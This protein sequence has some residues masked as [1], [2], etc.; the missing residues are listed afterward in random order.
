[1]KGRPLK[2]VVA[3][4]AIGFPMGG[5]L[6]MMMHYVLGLKQLGHE[7]L[8]LEDTSDWSYAYDPVRRS[9]DV[10]SSYG[11]RVL[12]DFFRRNGLEGQWVYNSALENRIYGRTRQELDRFCSEADLWLSLSGTNPL[13]E[14]YMRCRVKA[15]IDT[16]PVFTQ[17][18]IRDD[19]ITRDYFKAHD[20]CFTWGYN[21]PSLKT[22]VPL[23]GIDWKPTLPPILLEKWAPVSPPGRS[24]NT[25][26][27][28]DTKG[29][30]I[31]LDGEVFSWRKRPKYERLIDLPGQLPGL[32]LEIAFMGIE[33]DGPRYADHGWIL[34]DPVAV[35]ADPYNYMDYIKNSRAEFTVA[36]DQNVKLKSGWFSDRSASYLAAGRPV[37]TEDTGF[38]AYLPVGE[39]IF[40]YE[41]REEAIES[42]RTIERDPVHHSRAALHLAEEHFDARKVL[43]EILRE[44]GLA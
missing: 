18:K 30:D 19:E 3:G 14:N 38:S 2:I 34:R 25:I 39:G 32:P 42:I 20:V 8:F 4:F 29:R 26:G 12:E 21:L 24:Y 44:V 6:W 5:Q 9:Y 28:W 27:F 33:D 16:D 35:S 40:P 41:T 15:V 10:D 7:V 37:V 31:V 11:R 13:R 17:L 23:S 43:T 36:K 22:R 1:M